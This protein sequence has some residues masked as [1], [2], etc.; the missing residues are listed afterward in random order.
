MTAEQFAYWLQGFAELTGST[1]PTAEQWQSIR[2]HLST[3]FR[4][5]TPP[6]K[7]PIAGPIVAS[8]ARGPLNP[9]PGT[10]F[11][12]PVVGPHTDPRH[13]MYQPYRVGDFPIPPGTIIC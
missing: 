9:E 12:Q 1:P 8:P 5:V 10:V 11:P 3:V 2:E 6:L 7:E 4:K 13:P